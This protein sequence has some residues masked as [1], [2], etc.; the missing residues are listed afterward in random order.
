MLEDADGVIDAVVAK[1]LEGDVGAAALILGRIAPAIKAQMERVE[2]AL[3]PDAS[4]GDQLAQVLAA[5]AGGVLAPDAGR[6]IIE[7]VKVLSDVRVAEELEARIE[8][9]ESCHALR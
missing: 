9:L 3:D 8:A 5:V 7:S 4:T 6:Q 1:A 2:F